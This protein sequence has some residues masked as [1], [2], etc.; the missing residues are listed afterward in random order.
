MRKTNTS[1]SEL[2]FAEDQAEFLENFHEEDGAVLKSDLKDVSDWLGC[3]TQNLRLTRTSMSL[4]RFRISAEEM[5]G[6]YDE[7]PN[8]RKRTEMILEKLY[9]GEP[10]I[11][12]FI[13]KDDPH[14]FILEG[15]HRIVAFMI[16]GLTEVPVV[17]ASKYV[18]EP[19][20]EP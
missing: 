19:S 11:P 17:L 4:D 1:S 16:Y 5:L 6:T 7:F 20:L 12:V 8:D 10:P 2:K 3:R 14:A 15:R 13:E 9:A 18:L